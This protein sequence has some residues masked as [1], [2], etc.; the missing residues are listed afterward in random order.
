MK[1]KLKMFLAMSLSISVMFVP[2]ISDAQSEVLP[3]I[4]NPGGQYDPTITYNPHTNE[5]VL[6]WQDEPYHRQYN[7]QAHRLDQNGIPIG[8]LIPL[9]VT[10]ERQSS[11]VVVPRT[12]TDEVLA[13]WQNTNTS[14][15]D[16][17]ILGQLIDNNG[18]RFPEP[19]AVSTR[20]GRQGGP[21][22]AYC[23]AND[24]YLAS[25]SE[26]ED[27]AA[28]WR[29][30]VFGQQISSDGEVVGETVNI[31]AD[32]PAP[33]FQQVSVELVYNPN[34]N[35]FFAVF[36]D[37]RFHSPAVG[38]NDD[39][40]GQR[41]SCDGSPL[42]ED[43]IPISLQFSEGIGG[44][45]QNVPAIVYNSAR[46]QYLVVWEDRRSETGAD[47]EEPIDIYAQLLDGDGSLLYTDNMSNFPISLVEG[48]QEKIAL[49]YSSTAN[50]YLIVWQDGRGA[51]L[52]IYGQF[53]SSD[54]V[55]IG[56]EITIR[57]GVGNQRNPSIAYNSESDTFLVVWSDS[58]A[59]VTDRGDI[60]GSVIAP[61][62]QPA[63]PLPSSSLL[64]AESAEITGPSSQHEI[65]INEDLRQ[66]AI[67][68]TSGEQFAEWT[69]RMDDGEVVDSSAYLSILDDLFSTGC[70]GEG[71]LT[72][73]V[74]DIQNAEDNPDAQSLSRTYSKS[75]WSF[76]Q[77]Y[78]PIVNH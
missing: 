75:A 25:W 71:C 36:R 37:S 62:D 10:T 3:I 65:S 56:N 59:N 8:E 72:V 52:D 21:A 18:V 49:A 69:Y 24:R 19:I 29:F 12:N 7:I 78:L 47:S 20:P 66:Q 23:D 70:G 60:Y 30:Y 13:L 17:D 61:P 2:T 6:V 14:G 74:I 68:R 63:L 73:T 44:D 50:L 9:D 33:G 53:V 11:P 64:L 1:R 35:E 76:V 28:F 15:T 48:N 54:G 43:D 45:K 31:S 26:D 40:F 42:L 38:A 41:L 5:Y 46:D 32:A 22:V 27:A 34:R 55:L 39:I 51:D 4:E 77:L 16:N 58:G 57:S 67:V